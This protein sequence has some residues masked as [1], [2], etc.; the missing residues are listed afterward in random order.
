[1]EYPLPKDV[2]PIDLNVANGSIFTVCGKRT[3]GLK[4]VSLGKLNPIF[5]NLADFNFPI[6][7][8]EASKIAPDP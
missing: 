8:L 3:F 5:S 4:V 6:V 7:E 1:M 2:I